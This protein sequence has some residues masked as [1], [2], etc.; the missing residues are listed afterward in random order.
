MTISSKTISSWV[1]SGRLAPLTNSDKATP[2]PST[3]KFGRLPFFPYRLDSDRLFLEPG[4]LLQCLRRCLSIS[5]RD[6][7]FH[8]IQPVRS[9]EYSHGPAEY[10]RDRPN[11]LAEGTGRICSRLQKTNLSLY[12]LSLFVVFDVATH[13]CGFRRVDS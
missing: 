7:P 12:L 13:T 3:N 6:P 8:H 9:A 5:R 11:I 10:Y 1:T 2:R 4:Q